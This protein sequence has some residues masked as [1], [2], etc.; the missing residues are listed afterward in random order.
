MPQFDST[1]DGPDLGVLRFCGPFLLR[2]EE[3]LFPAPRCLLGTNDSEGWKPA[4]RCRFD[5]VLLQEPGQ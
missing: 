5:T 2:D 3:P 1:G 4:K